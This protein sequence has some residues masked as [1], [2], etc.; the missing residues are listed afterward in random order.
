MPYIIGGT[1][2]ALLPISQQWEYVA[3]GENWDGSTTY[4]RKK[5]VLLEF[6]DCAISAFKEGEDKCGGSVASVDILGPDSLTFSQ[7]NNVTL[8]MINRPK[9]QSVVVS[10]GWTIRI[11]DI[12]QT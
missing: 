12:L 6:S 9:V 2:V 5:N 4:A 7:Y 10:G 8:D 3:L 1:S 11:S